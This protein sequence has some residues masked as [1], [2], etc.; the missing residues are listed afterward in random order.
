MREEGGNVGVENEEIAD[1]PT[2]EG[3]GSRV[4]SCDQLHGTHE[5]NIVTVGLCATRMISLKERV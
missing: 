5:V 1:M 4:P 3:L 2:S